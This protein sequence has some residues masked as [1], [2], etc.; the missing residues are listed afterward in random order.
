[1]ELLSPV[2]G[3]ETETWGADNDSLTLAPHRQVAEM[4]F[5]TKT[6]LTGVEKMGN[7][8]TQLGRCTF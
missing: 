4:K 6:W 3:E 1:M 8:D 2:Q 7:S 5:L